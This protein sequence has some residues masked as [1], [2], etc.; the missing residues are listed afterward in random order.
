M[1]RLLQLEYA[2]PLRLYKHLP[3][4]WPGREDYNNL[5]ERLCGQTRPKYLQRGH[6]RRGV[7]LKRNEEISALAVYG[8]L[9]VFLLPHRVS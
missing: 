9:T 2:L 5:A 7:F 3:I 6:T 1:D 4:P 8:L